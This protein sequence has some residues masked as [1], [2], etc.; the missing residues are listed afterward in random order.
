[1]FCRKFLT[2]VPILLLFFYQLYDLIEDYFNYNYSIEL[3]FDTSSKILPSIT[4][5]IE[6]KYEI[7]TNYKSPYENQTIVCIYTTMYGQKTLNCIQQKVYMRYR[8]KEICLTFFNHKNF[9]YYEMYKGID[10]I[11]LG[12][13]YYTKQKVIIHPPETASHFEINN[14]FINKYWKMYDY[15]IKKVTRQLLPKPYSTD[16]HDYS[17]EL[18]VESQSRSQSYCML[19]YMRRKEFSECGN[20]SYWI[21]HLI[22]DKYQ[23]L[24]FSAIQSNCKVKLNHDILS[25]NC[26]PDC[27][28]VKYSVT[29]TDEYIRMMNPMAKIHINR[30]LSI[31]LLYKP[32]ITII[33]MFANLG[34]L[35]TMYFSFSLIDIVIII[36]KKL[37]QLFSLKIIKILALMFKQTGKLAIIAILIYQMT[38]IMKLYLETNTRIKI[39]FDDGIKLS[40]M[41]V[42]MEPLLDA[43]MNNEYYPEF[44]KIY[45]IMFGN[46]K[47]MFIHVQLQQIFR[48]NFTLF[49]ELTKLL[50]RKIKCNMEL[51]DDIQVD[52]GDIQVSFIH[53]LGMN[54]VSKFH[55]RGW[56]CADI[57]CA[58]LSH[59]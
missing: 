24:N 16:C 39:N 17:E 44:K 20:N 28:D 8:H 43:K 1:M 41:S 59:T 11:Y 7:E 10:F 52:C 15:K 3:E 30:P 42:I 57:H 58:S 9:N 56:Y 25:R 21:Q 53:L 2:Y 47:D 6:D 19:E 51:D 36:H 27:T 26:K 29:Y 33:N 23:D 45:N 31:G 54:K 48:Q 37:N 55:V 4:V 32:K 35:I 5:C 18:L 50:D 46:H 38:V 12:S 14:V 22:D 49:L 13:Y 34:G 40:K